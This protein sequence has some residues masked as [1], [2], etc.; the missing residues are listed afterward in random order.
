MA[1]RSNCPINHALEIFGDKWTLLIIRDLIFKGS[2][3]FSELKKMSEGIATN[4][5]SDRL[6]RLERYRIVD[7]LADGS[8]GRRA[9]YRL[10]QSGEDLIPLLLDIMVWSYRNDPTVNA[11]AELLARIEADRSS[12]IAE[13]A[14]GLK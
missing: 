5:L 13:M 12:V 8:D 7:K 14:A 9:H 11:P 10:T 2:T 6:A 1:K 3:S 4:I